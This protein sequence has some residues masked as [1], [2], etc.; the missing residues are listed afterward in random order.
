MT[1]TSEADFEVAL[2]N[3]LKNKGWED[4]VLKTPSEADLLQNWADILFQNNRGIDRL[5]DVPLSFLLRHPQ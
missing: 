5:N 4:K 2:I 1:F 3:E